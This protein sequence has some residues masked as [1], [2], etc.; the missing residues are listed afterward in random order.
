MR[1]APTSRAIDR[2]IS[3]TSSA[4]LPR[5]RPPPPVLPPSLSTS[6]RSTRD[7]RHAGTR[8]KATLDSIEIATAKPRTCASIVTWRRKVGNSSGAIRG[9]SLVPTTASTMPQAPPASDSSRFSVTSCFT[10]R[11]RLAP[12]A[13]RRA[14]SF[15]LPMPATSSRLATLAQ[16]MSRTKPTV[17]T[18]NVSIRSVPPNSASRIGTTRAPRFPGFSPRASLSCRLT[19]VASAAAASG[20]TPGFRRPMAVIHRACGICRRSLA[21]QK[22]TSSMSGISLKPAGITP[23]TILGSAS[24]RTVLP[25]ASAAPSNCCCHMVWLMTMPRASFS[26]TAS[27]KSS[28]R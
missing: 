11:P 4:T 19:A 18:R 23:M 3:A 16:P 9:Y 17:P 27:L 6:L 21:A 5:V 13:A 7:A 22:A 1:P 10:S 15:C 24:T 14:S 26:L 28:S 2:E 20:D 12:A 8:P 25:M